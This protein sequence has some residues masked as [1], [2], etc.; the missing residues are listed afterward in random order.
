M[1]SCLTNA[2]VYVKYTCHSVIALNYNYNI[3]KIQLS[4]YWGGET[5]PVAV[6][7]VVDNVLYF[8]S[9]AL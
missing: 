8:I 3:Q 6:L 4:S 5:V 9:N 7:V 2:I 1:A